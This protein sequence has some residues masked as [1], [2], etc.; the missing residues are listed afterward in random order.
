MELKEVMN[1]RKSVRSYTGAQIS[2]KQLNAVLT[3]AY[4]APVGMGKYAIF[5]FCPSEYND[6]IIQK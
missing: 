1:I 4:E 3:A 6:N 5:F 2:E